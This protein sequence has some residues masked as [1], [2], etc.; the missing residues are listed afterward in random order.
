VQRDNRTGDV[1]SS[2]LPNPATGCHE[3]IGCVCF[4]RGGAIRGH[5]Y[6]AQ[7]I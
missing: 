6:V 4:G 2:S 5:R 1:A 7:Q 3:M